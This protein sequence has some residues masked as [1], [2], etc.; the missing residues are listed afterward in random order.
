MSTNAQYNI[1]S[2]QNYRSR[3]QSRSL[4]THFST[5]AVSC[6]SIN[7]VPNEQKNNHYSTYQG[8]LITQPG[9][10][11]VAAEVEGSLV[12]V[13]TCISESS[14]SPPFPSEAVLDWEAADW[15]AVSLFPLT[16]VV[17]VTDAAV[18][19]PGAATGL[20]VDS[21]VPLLGVI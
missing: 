17:G 4:S 18:V 13:S 6:S 7:K 1:T 10:H 3:N 12:G 14:E 19:E 21:K 16:D 15:A 20:P 5:Y 8:G 2:C 11:A 9:L